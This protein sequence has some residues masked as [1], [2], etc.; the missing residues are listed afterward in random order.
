MA[1]AECYIRLATVG[2]KRVEG[3]LRSVGESGKRNFH[4]ISR[5][6]REANKRI[7]AF[8]RSMKFATKVVAVASLR[9]AASMVRSS[10]RAIDEQAKLAHS[11]G[12]TTKSIQLLSRAAELS[13][14]S[15]GE[16]EQA[17]LQ[18]TKRLSQA[19][20]GTGPAVKALEQLHLSAVELTEM[21]L[22]ERIEKI[23]DAIA[24][25]IPKAQQAGVAMQIFG[26]R[27]GLIF[28]RIDSKALKQATKDVQDFGVAV[29]DVDAGKVE[30]TNDAVT[31]LGLAWTGVSNRLTV[32]AAPTLEMIADRLAE[33]ARET[34]ALGKTF[35]FLGEHLDDI[36][37][38]MSALAVFLTARWV[39]SLAAAALG[40]RGLTLSLETM[41]TALARSGVGLAII[42]VGEL[43][44]RF[45]DLKTAQ[46][47]ATAST[48]RAQRA[49]ES[50]NGIAGLTAESVRDMTEAQRALK[51]FQLTKLEADLELSLARQK[52][53]FVDAFHKAWTDEESGFLISQKPIWDR[54]NLNEKQR[55]KQIKNIE[56]MFNSLK[57]LGEQIRANK[58]TA[59][60][61]FKTLS[62]YSKLHPGFN[63]SMVMGDL[64]TPLNKIMDAQKTLST[65][66]ADLTL[67]DKP[68][69]KAD[70]KGDAP[71]LTPPIPRPRL[72][73]PSAIG[74]SGDAI[75]TNKALQSAF[76]RPEA[77]K[78]ALD[79]R[80]NPEKM[81]SVRLLS[82]SLEQFAKESEKWGKAV[83]FSFTRAF[84]EAEDALVRF[85]RTGKLSLSSL[86]D[87]IVDDMLRVS[88][89]ASITGP[90]AG[91]MGQMFGSLFVSPG[92]PLPRPRPVLSS[93]A[94]GG[95]T[96]AGG[97][98][99]P[100]GIVHAGK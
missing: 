78:K 24:H 45:S 55:K 59:G 64:T 33:S 68:G 32:A 51:S 31:R 95:Y 72:S 17:T 94:S 52:N 62:D 25:Y 43:V 4:K 93:H 41:K 21:P 90:L 46:D 9:M 11:L 44:Y 39:K 8:G 6:A 92:V 73:L 60:E 99:D 5:E 3:D 49:L 89:R 36:L 34:G 16:V 47:E 88:I 23:Q 80:F 20:A 53:A 26:D 87:A 61:L 63:L 37:V 54:E 81:T 7:A 98:Y 77:L 96:G 18:L 58:I 69:K 29:S 66:K 10:L 19:A 76:A 57:K 85:T 38:H 40:V 79:D 91:L 15:M 28:T 14:I 22:D 2:G 13:G 70:K 75:V 30:E 48:E 65:V 35:E 27:A 83:S 12:T 50:L 42:G 100:A 56:A 67:F 84:S 1:T 97:K 74:G 82:S 71:S 86:A